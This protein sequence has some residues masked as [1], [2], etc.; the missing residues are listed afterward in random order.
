MKDSR[1]QETLPS[2][3]PVRW[4]WELSGLRAGHEFLLVPL[5]ISCCGQER[6]QVCANTLA[7]RFGGLK[8]DKCPGM[9]SGGCQ[10]FPP[11]VP[12]LTAV[13]PQLLQEDGMGNP[14]HS[15][16]SHGW[17]ALPARGCKGRARNPC[18]LALSALG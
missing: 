14:S 9:G 5:G 1:A 17:A 12:H 4:H 3:I 18:V 7:I 16:K 8:T 10:M 2:M 6:C 11:A 13:C 15:P